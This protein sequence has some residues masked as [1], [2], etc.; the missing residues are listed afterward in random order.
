MDTQY[1]NMLLAV[2]SIPRI[3]N[4]AAS[5]FTWLLLAGFLL[6]PGTFTSLQNS[7]S[8]SVES[9]VVDAVSH[10]GLFIVAWICTGIGAVGMIWLW[11][12]WHK[13]YI[14]LTNRIFTP[15]FMNA[16]AGVI[17]TITNVYGVQHGTFSAGSK[18]TIIVTAVIAGICGVLVAI[19]GFWLLRGVKKRHDH[20]VGKERAGQHG[21]GFIDVT[22]KKARERQPEAGMI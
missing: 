17:S 10:V 21:E 12:R 3:H 2:D 4:I 22:K 11:W 9:V 7:P 20:E 14:W 13:N 1:V 8:G 15:G 16:I 19:Y 5:F 18:S 6:F